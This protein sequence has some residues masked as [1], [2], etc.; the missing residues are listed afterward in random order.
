MLDAIEVFYSKSRSFGNGNTFFVCN[1]EIPKSLSMYI[2][3]S[4][5]D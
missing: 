4:K 3:D 5:C 1:K 2:E